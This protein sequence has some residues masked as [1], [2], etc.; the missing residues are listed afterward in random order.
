MEKT[1]TI[2][3]DEYYEL[4][5]FRDEVLSGKLVKTRSRNGT[6]FYYEKDD[7]IDRLERDQSKLFAD[8]SIKNNKINELEEKLEK[9]LKET[10]LISFIKVKYFKKWQTQ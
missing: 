8:L 2:S 9:Q 1:T 7:I 4:R 10:S 3:A 6:Y 5:K